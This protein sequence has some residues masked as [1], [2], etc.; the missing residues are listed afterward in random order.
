MAARKD[1]I[2]V[3]MLLVFFADSSPYETVQLMFKGL[4]S[5]VLKRSE[6]LL[7]NS[8]EFWA[9]SET[10]KF[11]VKTFRKTRFVPLLKLSTLLYFLTLVS[12]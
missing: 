2:V 7:S 8:R 3:I 9:E 4:P 1:D 11:R 5:D 10:N 12:V 6:T